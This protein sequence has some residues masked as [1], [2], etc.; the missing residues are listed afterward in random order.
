MYFVVNILKLKTHFVCIQYV[1]L[2]FE[3]FI[4]KYIVEL[5]AFY[6]DYILTIV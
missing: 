6:H 5:H 1:G 4:G 2:C 3:V